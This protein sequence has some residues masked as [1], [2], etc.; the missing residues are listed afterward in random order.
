M[1]PPTTGHE[2][3][4]KTVAVLGGGIS[5]LAASHYLTK[6]GWN[7]TLLESSNQLGGLGTYF[8][9][10]G[11]F[12]DRFYHVALPTDDHLI[13]LLEDI[14]LTDAIY[15]TNTSLGILYERSLYPLNTALDLLRFKPATLLERF[16]LGLTALYASHVARGEPLDNQTVEEWLTRLSGA[17]AFAKLWKPLLEAKFGDA[18]RQ[19]P[20]L[21]YWS[22]FNREK[23]TKQEVKGY[24]RGGYKGLI[25][26][27]TASL[28]SRGAQLR[29]GSPVAAVELADNGS[30]ALTVS[31]SKETYD[32]VVSTLPLVTLSKIATGGSV[33]PWLEKIDTGIDYQ[34]VVN[35]MLIMNRSL[36]EHYWTAC[37]ECGVPFQ[38]IVE[39]TRAIHLDDSAGHHLVYLM[40]YVHRT[41]PLFLR[42]DDDIRNEYVA[43]LMDLRPDLRAEDILDTFVFKAPF[44]E[45][46]YTP[47]FIARKPP[48]ELVPD[49]IYLA[50]SAQVYPDVNSWNSATGVAKRAVAAL[51]AGAAGSPAGLP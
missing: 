1:M 13:A 11:D 23:G 34:G 39:T 5:G 2:M 22:R 49:K 6:A 10:Q 8:E 7:V 15:W 44:V 25:D 43:A 14:G 4:A 28:S 18:Y 51:V 12:L 47:G 24:P 40:N 48:F 35:V 33:D 41:D 9:Y 21:W 26:T 36:S 45:P 19:I 3:P 17:G 16:R 27:L 46:L 38:G 30:V 31:A 20:A 29:L 32:R 42:D 37:V 50:T